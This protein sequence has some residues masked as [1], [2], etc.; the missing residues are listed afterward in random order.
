MARISGIN[1]PDNKPI[2]IALTSVYGI[3][4]TTAKKICKE[5]KIEKTLRVHKLSDSDI[6]KIRTYIDENIQTEGDVR[7]ESAMNI[8]RLQDLRCYRGMRHSMKLPTRGQNTRN[9]AR[10]RKGKAVA[11]AGKKKV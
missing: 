5:T 10:T 4:Q 6:L 2:Y 9:N 8:K 3:G 7:R 11:I 1:I